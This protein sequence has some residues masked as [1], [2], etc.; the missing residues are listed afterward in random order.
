ML[1]PIIFFVVALILALLGTVYLI[2]YRT[3]EKSSGKIATTQ[4]VFIRTKA[5]FYRG[6]KRY[7]PVYEYT[8]GNKTYRKRVESQPNKPH[9]NS[10]AVYLKAFPRIAYIKYSG[11]DF[12]MSA[13]G[14]YSGATLAFIF[15]LVLYFIF[16]H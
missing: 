15:S 5:T 11:N 2:I 10:E 12:G 16:S 7:Y 13:F 9:R 8:V 1:I 6:R 4:A 3:L 14:C